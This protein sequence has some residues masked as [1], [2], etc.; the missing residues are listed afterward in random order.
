MKRAIVQHNF[1]SGFGDAINCIYEYYTTCEKLK[2][3]GYKV[4]LLLNLKKSS[5]FVEDN[6]FDFFNID[7]FKSMFE[8]VSILDSPIMEKTFE[9]TIWVN[10]IN[11]DR[12]GQHLWDL[13]LTPDFESNILNKINRFSYTVPDYLDYIEIFN[14]ELIYE[15]KSIKKSYGLNDDYYSIYYRTYDQEDNLDSCPIFY[16]K[17]IDTIYNH[18]KIFICSNSFKIKEYVKSLD[19]NKVVYYDIPDEINFGNHFYTQNYFLNTPHILKSRT[20]YVIFDMLTLSDSKGLDFFSL[21]NRQSNFLLLSC[22]KKVKITN[23]LIQFRN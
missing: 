14:S 21:W 20:K 6:F 22:V 9:D 13:F 3:L 18:S 17:F 5:Y 16:E 15:Y 4:D 11:V 10:S 2:K 1:T 8:N 12:P 19:V 7:L 23:N